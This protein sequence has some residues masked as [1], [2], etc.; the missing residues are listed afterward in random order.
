MNKQAWMEK[1]AALGFDGLEITQRRASSR[2]L[3]WFEG[4]MDTFMTSRLLSTSIRGMAD[5]KIVSTSMEKI[6]D[7][8]MDEVLGQLYASAKEIAQ[9]E[10]DVLVAPM[11]TE[12]AVST[13]VWVRP[14]AE[15]IKEVLAS[16]EKKCLAAD[17]RITQVTDLAFESSGTSRELVNSL[18]TSIYDESAYQII[19]AGVSAKENDETYDTFYMEAV[20]NLSTFDQDAFVAKIIDKLKARMGAKSLS[21]RTCK[22]ILE[23]KAMTA[24]L[25][26]LKAMFYGSMIARGIS[27]LT[28]KLHEKIFSDS[29]TIIDDPRNLDS[30]FMQNYDDEGTPTRSKVLVENGVFKQMLHNTKSAIKMGE[31]STGNGFS[32]GGGA[33]DVSS[34]NLYIEPG[35]I[36]FDSLLKKMD[37][38]VV[39]SELE[40][41][42]AGIDFV[43]T[44]FSLQAKGFLVE[45]GE[46]VRPL[47]LITVA[48]NFMDLM[49][50]VEAVADDLKWEISDTAAPSILFEEAAIGGNEEEL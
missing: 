18:G 32:S 7:E 22:V 36:S 4:E 41:L 19:A 11:E 31:T 46:I 17:P 29:I 10:Q 21:A 49:N 2:A 5:G 38:G 12:E 45:N 35:R 26:S 33:T 27:P 3:S 50:H 44:N 16:I 13:K 43:S 20:S 30:L 47:T 25:S 42:H 28:G 37:N 40:G 9:T 48:G 23:R 14:D 39:I 8:D 34:M 24:L 15:Q 1:A 6:S